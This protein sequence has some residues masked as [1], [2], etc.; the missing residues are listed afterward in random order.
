MKTIGLISANYI[1]NKFG[2]LTAE[3]TLASLPF[4]GRYR[5]VDFALSNMVNSGIKT[6]GL[7]TPFNSGSLLD[8]VG[9][10]KPWSLGRKSGG[11][12]ILPGSIYGIHSEGDRFVMRDIINNKAFL[13]RDNADYVIVSGS[14]DVFNMDYSELIKV[15]A[16]SSNP[17]TLVYKHVDDAERYRGYFLERDNEGIVDE[18]KTSAEG[19]ADYFMDLCIFDREYLIEFIQWYASLAHMDLFDIIRENPNIIGIGT[20]EFD[21]YLGKI[22]DIVD[23]V[24]VSR[25]LFDY[26]TRKKLFMGENP[27]YTK[28]QDEAPTLMGPDA[29]VKNSLIAAGCKIE[30]KV[31]NSIIFRSTH[32]APGAVVKNSVIMMHGEIGENALVHGVVTDKN[33]VITAGA[34]IA[35]GSE[36]PLIV[37]KGKKI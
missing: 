15:H 36:G 9:D 17:V 29:E 27:V 23:Y 13:E 21:G 4:G 32:I 5:L 16:A 10:G 8:H 30:G 14:S 7:I 34:K 26:E 28:V 2:E 37:G 31:E 18:I 12:F 1:S 19:E 24:R 3:R 35:G 22:N 6:V 11:L 25:D 20:Y 33:V